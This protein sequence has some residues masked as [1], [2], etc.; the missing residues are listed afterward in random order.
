VFYKIENMR[1]DY[2]CNIMT[3]TLTIGEKIWNEEIAD[4]AVVVICH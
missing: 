3:V 2:W 1:E 4:W